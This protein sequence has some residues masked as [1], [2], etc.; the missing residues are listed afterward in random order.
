MYDSERK[1]NGDEARLVRNPIHRFCKTLVRRIR[2]SHS[3][4]P[5]EEDEAAATARLEA[6]ET[7]PE[8]INRITKQGKFDWGSFSAFED[9]SIEVERAGIR[10]RFRNFSELKRSLNHGSESEMSAAT[11]TWPLGS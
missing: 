11:G 6:C 8:P 3:N 7:L 5:Q 2:L 10:R 9:G 4:A 1:S